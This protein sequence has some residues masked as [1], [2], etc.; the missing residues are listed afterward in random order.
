[1]ELEPGM[2]LSEQGGVSCRGSPLSI[3][4][5]AENLY[6]TH[7]KFSEPE[8]FLFC[9]S[10]HAPGKSCLS[11]MTGRKVVLTVD[12][13]SPDCGSQCLSCFLSDSPFYVLVETSG[14]SA[15]H[16]AEKLTNVLEQVLNSG[17]VTDG[18]MATDQRKV[19]VL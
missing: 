17:L 14:S 7:V 1:M 2:G 4:L 5:S 6:L 3:S 15:G 12:A 18:T 9:R 13:G 11:C 8:C 10:R 16:D 19:Q